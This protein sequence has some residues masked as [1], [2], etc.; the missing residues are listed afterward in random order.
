MKGLGSRLRALRRRN[1]MTQARLAERLG[2]S[3][4]YLNLIEHGRRPL[5]APLLIKVAG[6][7]DVDLQ[8]FAPQSDGRMAN[9]LMEAFSDTIFDGHALTN[10]DLKDFIETSPNVARAVLTLY[11]AFRQSRESARDL[12]ARVQADP[13]LPSLESWRLPS[14]EVSDL[15]QRHK[16]Y[17]PNLEQA[18]EDLWQQASL[19][20]DDLYGGLVRY[21]K[22]EHNIQVRINRNGSAAPVR[23]YD[24]AKRILWLSELIP[25]SSRNFQVAVQIGLLTQSPLLDQLAADPHLTTDASRSLCRVAMANYFAG[26]ITMPYGVFLDAATK[27]R[28]DVEKM[29]YRF[30]ASFEQVC[31]RLTTLRREGAQG[32]PFHFLKVDIAGNISKRFSASGISFA[33]FSGACP[34]WN[35]VA[36]FMTPGRI[37]RQL[38]QMHDG[39]IYFCIARTVTRPNGGYYTPGAISAITLGCEAHHAHQM[40]Y[41]DG[42]NLKNAEAAVPI[43]VTCRLCERTDC[44]QR[45][46]PPMMR[47]LLIDEN[48]RGVSFYATT[49]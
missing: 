5:T 26:A 45:V 36:A 3:A 6:I 8:S 1:N 20:L 43:G 29:A 22:D 21:L 31:H 42:M 23:F 30:Q 28:Y 16:N 9:N 15:I 46:F 37:R 32:I 39:P 25:T 13:Q 33:R 34:R 14:E 17:F 27:L 12:A 49:P 35:L 41:A 18:A 24:P 40:V 2:I 4:S 19:E 7:F 48:R 38:S 47:P 44:D 10:S 11:E